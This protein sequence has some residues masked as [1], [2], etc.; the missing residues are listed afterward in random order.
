MR[1]LTSRFARAKGEEGATAVIVVLVHHRPV[2]HGRPRRGRRR[3]AAPPSCHGERLGCRGAR[4]GEVLRRSRRDRPT[5]PREQ[6]ADEWAGDNVDGVNVR[7]T[8]ILQIA[9]CDGGRPRHPPA[10]SASATRRRRTSSSRPCSAIRTPARSRPRPPRS[11]DRRVRRTRSRSSSTPAASTTASSTRTRRPA[12]ECYVWEDNSN[13]TGAA[14]RVRPARPADRR[15]ARVRVGLGRRCAVPGRGQRP[16]RLDRRLPRLRRRRSAVELPGSPPTCAAATGSSESAWDLLETR[17]KDGDILFF[18]VNRCY[19]TPVGNET[20][21]ADQL[22]RAA[23]G[24][25]CDPAPVRHHRVRGVPPDRRPTARTRRSRRSGNCGPF[26][27]SVPRV[28]AAEPRHRG[29]HPGLLHRAPP[30]GRST[31]RR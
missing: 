22:E 15:P 13:T 2:R 5:R 10:T 31:R 12:P 26:T 29:H 23:R 19:D 24:M 30:P 1:V 9:N 25:R 8:N 7:P 16:R 20:E 11:G 4:R 27:A 14:V 3:A 17:S 21:R 28:L 18:P 6:A